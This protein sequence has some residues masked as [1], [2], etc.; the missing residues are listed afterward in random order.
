MISYRQQSGAV[1]LTVS[2]RSV[3]DLYGYCERSSQTQTQT[4]MAQT[5]VQHLSRVGRFLLVGALGVIVNTGTLILFHQEARL[6]LIFAS[7]LAFEL[8]IASNFIWNNR[9]TFGTRELSLR[10]F[11]CFNLV[12][13]GGLAITSVTLWTLVTELGLNYLVANLVGIGLATSWNLA[14]SF[15]WI[16]VSR[17]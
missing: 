4:P 13:L 12:S 5:H 3:A 10:R 6:P 7:T 9:W 2:E 1:H 17:P 16:W 14:G 15:R 8:A 11:A